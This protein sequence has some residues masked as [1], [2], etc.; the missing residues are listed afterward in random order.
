MNPRDC[1]LLFATSHRSVVTV[2][3]PEGWLMAS[4]PLM[5]RFMTTWCN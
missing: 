1:G 5:I 4:A 3:V 2:T